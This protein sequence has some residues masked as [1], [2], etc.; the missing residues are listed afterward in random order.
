[1]DSV[2]W[3]RILKILTIRH[4]VCTYSFFC[5]L[6]KLIVSPNPKKASSVML[7]M[8]LD[9]RSRWRNRWR[10]LRASLGIEWMLLSP[11]LRLCRFSVN[12]DHTV[13][14]VDRE[15]VCFLAVKH[16]F[17][18]NHAS[19]KP[20]QT[21]FLF[22]SRPRDQD[23]TNFMVWWWYWWPAVNVSDFIAF[24]SYLTDKSVQY[25][26]FHDHARTHLYE[27]EKICTCINEICVNFF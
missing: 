23:S 14:I 22:S 7:L 13:L 2:S 10:R 24:T 15:T 27:T 4:N 8:L 19:S 17:H 16:T 9:R 26:N 18:L 21:T 20:K 12:K 1:M 6:R 25:T 5:K 3:N 11:S